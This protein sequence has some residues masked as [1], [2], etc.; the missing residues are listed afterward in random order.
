MK[1]LLAS[2][3]PLALGHLL[4]EVG[5]GDGV[6]RRG[7][8][9]VGGGGDVA[10][11]TDHPAVGVG[12]T[13]D[14]GYGLPQRHGLVARLEDH[15]AAPVDRVAADDVLVAPRHVHVTEHAL[16]LVPAPGRGTAGQ[17]AAVDATGRHGR[18][19]DTRWQ[20]P[21]AGAVTSSAC[22]RLPEGGGPRGASPQDFSHG[23]L[24]GSA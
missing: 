4:T 7:D 3:A 6:V 23:P 15:R 2:L 11:D 19:T 8:Q 12:V 20:T 22:V 10:A 13:K 16:R 14:K 24:E 5:R 1:G 18:R 21:A 17:V 9:G